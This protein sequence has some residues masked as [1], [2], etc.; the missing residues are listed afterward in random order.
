MFLNPVSDGKIVLVGYASQSQS[1]PNGLY[2]VDLQS[3]RILWRAA[4]TTALGT[5]GMGR[6]LTVTSG[7]STFDGETTGKIVTR[8]RSI[9]SDWFTGN[10]HAYTVAAVGKGNA[11]LYAFDKGGHTLWKKAVGPPM[12]TTGWAHAVGS[13]AVYV[14]T[15]KPTSGVEA[16]DPVTGSV[17]WHRSVPDVQR[18]VLANNALFVLTYG[19]GQPV[20][21]IAFSAKTGSAI[22]SLSLTPG[23][24]A[25]PDLNALMVADGMLF[26][27]AVGPNGG[28]LLAL[29]S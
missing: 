18:M 10:G 20:R 17:L 6:I 23:Y 27:R 4:S 29:R 28:E 16:V 25:F 26:I 11:T 15:L 14:S 24:Y 3:H 2:A 8:Q 12:A 21:V 19:L 7:G 5:I 1:T 9:F 13:A 22:G